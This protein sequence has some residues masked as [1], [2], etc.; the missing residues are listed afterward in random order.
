MADSRDRQQDAQSGKQQQR[1]MPLDTRLLSD[2]VIE[3]NI[4][5]KNVGIYPPGHVQIVNS[6]DRAYQ[7]LLKL[8]EIRQEMTLGVA[9]DTLFVGQDYLDRKNPVY[10]DFALSLNQQGIAAV[11]F[12]NGLAR[13]ELVRFH[14]ILTTK[15]EEIAAA[16]GIAAVVAQAAIPHIR[17]LP[18]DYSSFHLTEEQEI[19]QGQSRRGE[20]GGEGLWQDFV[21]LLAADSLATGGTGRSLKDSIAIDPAEL[22]RLLNE[23]KVDPAAAVQSYDRVISSHVRHAEERKQ[24]TKE[25]SATL[26]H[27]NALLKNLHPELR[28]QFLSTAFRHASAHESAAAEVVGGMTDDMVIDML[29]QASD[30]GREISPTLTGLI[31]KLSSVRGPEVRQGGAEH[32]EKPSGAAAPEMD[33]G[34]MNRLFD[35]ESYEQYVVADYDSMLKNVA[36]TAESMAASPALRLPAEEINQ[37]LDDTHLDFQ[38]GRALLAFMEERIDE[39]DY[40]EFAKKLG[41]LL[42]DLLESGNFIL[43]LDALESLRR[44]GREK[45]QEGIKA[46]AAE[47]EQRFAD[48]D[49]IRRSVESFDRWSRTKGREAA[50]LLL[51]LGPAVVPGLM[52]LFANDQTPG[53]R[54]MLFDL[55]CN[56]GKPAVAEAQRR[57]R[58]PR[59]YYV[60]NLLMLIR[61]AGNPSVAGAV[62]PLLAHPDQKVR[63]EAL[64]GLLRFKDPGAVG[65]LRQELHSKDPDV[66][67][68]AV[69]L[70]GQ[71]RIADVVDDLLSMF[72]KVILFETDYTVNEELIKAL[73][74]IGDARALPDLEK[75]AKAGWSLYP[76]SLARMKAVL[77]ESLGRYPRDRIGALL[78]I[79]EAM[80]DER[81]RRAC[82]KLTEKKA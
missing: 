24:L 19:V 58:D 70:A 38:I 61:W 26:S 79:G 20:Q 37:A 64:A 25:Q 54:K 55:L 32:G 23:R 31:G 28:K 30:E 63:L 66:S 21:S 72:K 75:I 39:E 6:I 77:F 43:L 14:R 44:H 62:R 56:F 53:G 1:D 45:E 10:R 48:P 18:I 29:R 69:F 68:Q 59:A 8:F 76:A 9:K 60:R 42:T 34:R 73:G 82:W 2:A 51:A 16:G 46:A 49:F 78:D 80:A 40:R 74:E 71:F 47:V 33:Q 27:L 22:A 5:R 81:I 13:D 36:V 67:S 4:S 35:R 17:I 41:G 50:G 7:V 12:V 15:A 3:L 11:T 65:L 57:L 52:D